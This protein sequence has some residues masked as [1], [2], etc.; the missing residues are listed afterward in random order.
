MVRSLLKLPFA[1]IDFIMISKV[2]LVSYYGIRVYMF[3]ILTGAK[4]LMFQKRLFLLDFLTIAIDSNIF[5]LF[6]LFK[7][8]R[9]VMNSKPVAVLN[10]A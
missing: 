7:I 10:S 1:V 9:F 4:Q 2:V 6:G 8:P 5:L 3:L